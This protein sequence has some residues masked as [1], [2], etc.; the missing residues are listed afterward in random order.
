[1]SQERSERTKILWILGGI[2]FVFA[3]LLTYPLG[4]GLVMSSDDCGDYDERP[5]CGDAQNIIGLLPIAAFVVGLLILV[6]GIVLTRRYKK[7]FTPWLI[8][9]WILLLGMAATSISWASVGP[10]DQYKQKLTQ[11][12]E[13]E[14][15]QWLKEVKARPKF[16][17]VKNRFTEMLQRIQADTS[18]SMPE[19]IWVSVSDHDWVCSSRNTG[20]KSMQI[21]L[22]VSNKSSTKITSEQRINLDSLIRNIADDY[23]LAGTA[24]STDSNSEP[25]PQL[26]LRDR[27]ENTLSTQGESQT[28][29]MLNFQSGCSLA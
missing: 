17:E 24:L 19:I 11:E 6:I 16:A 8:A 12:E 13:N 4:I 26:T 9:A 28:E 20:A 18:R 2:L 15:Q 25:I 5:I 23:G 14:Y 1:M 29:I 22:S 27:Y 7:S 10:S 21:T 3:G